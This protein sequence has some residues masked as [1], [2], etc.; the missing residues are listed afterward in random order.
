MDNVQCVKN[1]FKEIGCCKV[2]RH[3]RDGLYFDLEIVIISGGPNIETYIK[4][5]INAYP[6]W[7]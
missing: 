2:F 5:N 3:N 4:V 1:V 7:S 6:R